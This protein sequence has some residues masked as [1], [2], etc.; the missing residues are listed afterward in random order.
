MDISS[1][2]PLFLSLSPSLLAFSLPLFIVIP[3]FLLFQIENQ[4][5]F[6]YSNEITTRKQKTLVFNYTKNIQALEVKKPTTT[7]KM[8]KAIENGIPIKIWKFLRE[9]DISGCLI[10]GGECQSAYLQEIKEIV[11]VQK[12]QEVSYLYYGSMKEHES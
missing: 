5:V 7:M 6:L 8:Q 10:N 9:V 1:P 12:L 2:R 4:K 3:S 11:R